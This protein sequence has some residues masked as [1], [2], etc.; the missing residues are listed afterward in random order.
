MLTISNRTVIVIDD[1]MATGLTMHAAVEALSKHQPLE[2]IIATP[3]ASHQAIAKLELQVDDLI[4]MV[5]PKALGA[6]GFW[7]EDF[8]QTTDRE[9]CNLLECQTCHNFAESC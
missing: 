3:V 8:S 5:A 6:V 9:V 4:C 2:I 1:G 7:Y